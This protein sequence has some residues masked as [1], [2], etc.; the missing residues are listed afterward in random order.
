MPPARLSLALTLFA[1]ACAGQVRPDA[2]KPAPPPRPVPPSRL[3]AAARR[4]ENVAIYR[5]D[6][7]AIKEANIRLGDNVT[8]VS[9]TPAENGYFATEHGRPVGDS[10]FLRPATAQPEWHGE[11]FEF[12]QNSVFNARTFFQAGPVLPSRRNSYG[13]RVTGRLGKLGSLTA[14][15]GQRKIRGMVNGNVLAP[16][17]EE[18]TP[19]A[20]DPALRAVVSRWLAAYPA[21]LPNRPDFD[22][23]ALNTNAPQ[24]IN[25]LDGDLRLDR[26]AG[27]KG[28]LSLF[29]AIS[30]QRVKAFQLVAGQNPNTDI[31]SQRSRLT[32]RHTFSPATEAT[33]GFHF[34]R[35]TSLLLPE[36]NAVGPRVRMGFQIEELGPDGMFPI[37][38]AQNS[39]R[40]A[41][42]VSKM[43]AGGSHALTF[44]ADL[45]RFQL[46]GIESNNLR[47][48]FQFSSNFGRSA[49]DNFRLG[50]PTSYE[51][52]V[53]ELARGFRNWT[54]NAYFG[55]KWKLGQRLQV[56][57]GLRFNAVAAPVEVNRLNQAPYG[58]D[59]NNFSPRFS[60]AWRLPAEWMLRASYTASFGE[61]LPVTYQQIRNNAPR[62]LYLQVP[63]PDLLNPLRGID[64]TTAGVRNSPTVLAPDL[65]SPYA[66]QYNLSLERKLADGYLLRLGYVGSRSFK[67][68][69]TFIANRADP[70]PGIALT[71]AT[72]DQRRPDPRYYEVKSIVNA[73]IAYLD[74]A[75][76][77]LDMPL[78]KGFSGSL[79]YTFGKAIDEGADYASTAANQDMLRGRS[80]WQ[81]D[82]LRDKKSLSL[83][84]STHALLV[85]YNYDLPR[86]WASRG[87]PGWLLNGWQVSGTTLVKSGTPLTLYIGSDAPGFGNVDG[88]PSD[89]P[90]I[91]DPSILG[92]T[93]SD[94][95][96]APL[97][98]RR[99][100]FA[101]IPPGEHRGSLGRNTFRKSGIANFNAALTKQWRAPRAPHGRREWLLLFRGEAYNLTNHPQF[102]E[103][104]RNL[105]SPSFGRITNT[106]NDGRVFQLGLRLVL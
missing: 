74:A 37:D 79:S 14:N 53:G 50:T 97:I 73:G 59:C 102:D 48:Y 67:L 2:A 106:L 15:A 89:R 30:R 77:T 6:N 83:F 49:L 60:I 88:G 4:N 42:L 9:E 45:T 31:H 65:V 69:N 96:A 54:L 17:A 20:T 35:V 13:G 32:W 21:A 81:Y 24:R 58:C 92:R 93:I 7:N 64:L 12:H 56:Y 100:R 18:R 85:N 40:Y 5:I 90:N 75:Q 99:D 22:P 55:D 19:L 82:S 29:H 41:A 84:D 66:H 95:N 23:R 1:F 3:G 86:L 103:P 51:V 57:Y 47:G 68:L 104:Q 78:R 44:G 43:A 8:I 16:L 26:P 105:S 91:L 27:A 11:L 76:L 94:P 25:E 52:T 70:V 46:N 39:F 80:Q 87:W 72:V 61:I 63:N 62:V 33:L 10:P 71:T 98:L 34:N 101:F 36:P 28:R 38:R